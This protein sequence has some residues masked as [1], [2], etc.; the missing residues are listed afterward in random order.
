MVFRKEKIVI[1][2]LG[3]ELRGDDGA[4]ILFGNL[5]RGKIPLKVINGGDAPENYIGPISNECPET[6]LVVDAMNFGGEPGDSAL[7]SY[8]SLEKDS[9]ST[10]GSLKLF[11]EF[12]E[13]ITCARLLI[14]GI[15]PERLGLGEK[16]SP[17]VKVGVKNLAEKFIDSVETS[18]TIEPF[19]DSYERKNSNG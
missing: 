5:V 4:G 10:H 7:F 16:I 1:V 17:L 3:N 12:L 13:R 18:H 14:L 15:Q 8:K 11:A 2:T 19:F 9:V 6:I